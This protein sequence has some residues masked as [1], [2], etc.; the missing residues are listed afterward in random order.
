MKFLMGIL[1]TVFS[2]AASADQCAVIDHA[3]AEAFTKLVNIGD[4]VGFL[5]EPCGETPTEINSVPQEYV[6]SISI[7]PFNEAGDMTVSINGKMVDLAYTYIMTTRHEWYSVH[8]NAAFLVGCEAQGVT[9]QF[10][11]GE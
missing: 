10:I 3:Q 7:E 1:V 2:M 5:C 6:Q 8:V 4:T 11:G 9:P